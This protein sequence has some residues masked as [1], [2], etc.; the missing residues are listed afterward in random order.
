[1]EIALAIA[2]ILGGIV[3][4]L[5]LWKKFFANETLEKDV[6]D[7]WWESSTLKKS[8]EKKG[9][10]FRWS[11]PNKVEERLNNGYEIILQRCAFKKYKLLNKSGQVLLG[12]KNT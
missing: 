8:L 7:S 1:M 4:F 9:Y 10:V 12:K 11:N 5:F 2:T 6:N 3:A